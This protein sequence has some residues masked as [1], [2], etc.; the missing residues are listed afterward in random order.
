VFD[1]G[2]L[3]AFA[4]VYRARRVEA[5]VHPERGRGIGSHSTGA[6]GLYERVGMDVKR[7]YT[8][9]AREP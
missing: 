5:T 6:L 2:R 3:V 4:E 8:H 7:S 1:G 9:F